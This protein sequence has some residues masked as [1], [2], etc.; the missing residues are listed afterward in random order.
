MLQ[1]G[2]ETVAEFTLKAVVAGVA[3]GVLFGAANAYI[4][5]R[6][7]MTITASIPAAVMTVVAFRGL[8]LRNTILESNL[9]QTI[10]ELGAASEYNIGVG[11]AGEKE[12]HRIP[13]F[14]T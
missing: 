12:P 10:M 11:R 8:R 7:G 2:R 4:G 14:D 6:V 5:L 13:R 3:L 9:S 1:I